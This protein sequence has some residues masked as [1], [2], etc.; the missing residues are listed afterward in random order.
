MKFG[1]VAFKYNQNKSL[2]NAERL[3][4]QWTLF[5]KLLAFVLKFGGDAISFTVLY[6]LQ[7]LILLHLQ[8]CCR[9][10]LSLPPSLYD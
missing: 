6:R 8:R 2:L 5:R 1:N 3:P 4:Q 9:T 7:H 10:S